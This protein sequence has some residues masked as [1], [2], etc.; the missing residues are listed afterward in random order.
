MAIEAAAG[1]PAAVAAVATVDATEVDMKY[2]ATLGETNCW[3]FP[4]DGLKAKDDVALKSKTLPV[5][6]WFSGSGNE[7]VLL[8][9]VA[10]DGADTISQNTS[11]ATVSNHTDEVRTV[12]KTNDSA[13]CTPEVIWSQFLSKFTRPLG[14]EGGN[15]AF[16]TDFTTRKDGMGYHTTDFTF[17]GFQRKYLTYVPSTYD[18]SKSAPLVVVLHGYTATMYA[19]AE[20]SQWCDVAEANGLIV[21]FGQAYPNVIAGYPNIPCPAWI[22]PNLFKKSEGNTDDF[23]YLSEVISRTE[24][25]YAIDKSRV[26]MTGHSNGSAMTIAFA[27][28]QPE[29]VA[30][31]GPIGF[32]TPGITDIK[33]IT[34]PAWFLKGE[35]DGNGMT[36]EKGN[37]NIQ[38][39]EYWTKWN[40]LNID[41]AAEAEEGV[42]NRFLTRTWSDKQG[43]PVVKFSAVRRSAHSYFPEESW[44]LWNEFFSHYS[45]VN[46]VS[47]YDGKALSL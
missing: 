12:W 7:D 32:T 17:V 14:Y 46:G 11:A 44:K 19:L 21:V 41:D 45:K 15:L 6:A 4:A 34:V 10:L 13:V 20:E 18:A 30:A 24:K 26:Y 40:K 37:G 25:E 1:F 38:C 29:T 8:H 23:A 47:Y 5:P 16:A 27:S 9:F 35:F 33:D 2:L 39:M 43:D 36:L 22:T 3:P 42:G 31:V 28:M